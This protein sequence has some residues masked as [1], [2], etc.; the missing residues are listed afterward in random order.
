M[1]VALFDEAHD[2][3]ESLRQVRPFR[4]RG[5]ALRESLADFVVDVSVRRLES[6]PLNHLGKTLEHIA[7]RIQ[8]LGAAD[9]GGNGAPSEHPNVS[10]FL[11]LLHRFLRCFLTRISASPGAVFCAPADAASIVSA[12]PPNGPWPQVTAT[13]AGGRKA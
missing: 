2:L 5:R 7:G 4:R 13:A 9:V 10:G 6:H 1:I 3:R 8:F 12:E 11:K